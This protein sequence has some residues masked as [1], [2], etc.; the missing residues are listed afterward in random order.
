MLNYFETEWKWGKSWTIIMDDVAVV[1]L[2]FMNGY[3]YAWLCDLKVWQKFQH[4][5]IGTMLMKTA[6]KIAK[7]NGFDE[8]H[9]KVEKE[10]DFLVKWYE[11]FGYKIIIE[12]DD[13]LYMR[14]IF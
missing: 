7:E 9:L 1:D 8:I 6:E 3:R 5:G 13:Y 10:K 12:E 2:Q 4:Q 14:K 11:K